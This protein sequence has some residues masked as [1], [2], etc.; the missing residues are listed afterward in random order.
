MKSGRLWAARL[1][2][3]T[4]AGLTLVP[5]VYQ[6]SL[7][8][9]PSSE[10]FGKPLAP[11]TW[12][13]TLE[14]YRYVLERIPYGSYL[15]N[16][17]IFA[18]GVTLGQILLGA[19]AAYAFA[20][21]RFRGRE[22][23]FALVLISLMV[24]FAVTY[25]PNYLLVARL[26][27]LNTLPGLILPMLAPGFVIFLLRQNF[28][29]FPKEI[30]EAARVD[31]A[32]EAQVLWRILVPGNL[33]AISAIAIFTFINTWNQL[34][35]PMLVANDPRVYVLTTAV[36]RFAG[37]EGMANWG[38]MM[39]MA[40]LATLPALVLYLLMRRPILE[41]LSEGAVKG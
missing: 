25:L 40:N 16:T 4:T 9:K 35:W 24:P 11:L 26:G 39:A 17:L 10:I 34:I 37:G 18:F 14:H 15:F 29:A 13:L 36:Q 41:A 22:L 12:P 31:G 2:L 6:L 23:L 7:S 8:L 28:K 21:H 1:L 20:Y 32:T 3:L 38:A 30:L 33:P 27:L 5:L 19:L